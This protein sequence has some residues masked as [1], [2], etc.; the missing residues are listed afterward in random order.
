MKELKELAEFFPKKLYAVGGYVRDVLSGF[1][2]HDIDIAADVSP[3]EVFSILEKT[4][5]SVKETSK[6]LMTLKIIGS[7]T[8]YYEYTAFRTDSY[9]D[10]HTPTAVKRTSDIKI[11]ALRRDFTMN[12]IYL[13]IETGEFI[14]PLNGIEDIKDKKVRMTRESTFEEDGLRLMRLCRQ[15]AELG[16][17]IEEKTLISAQNNAFRIDEISPERIREELDRILVADIRYGV[18]DAQCRGLRLLDEIGV[19]E[20]ILPEITKGK[21]MEQRKDFHKFDVFNHILE[22]V[23]LAPPEIRLA[24]LLHDVGKPYCMEKFGKYSRH[25]VEGEWI[26]KNILNRLRYSNAVTKETLFLV[27]NHMFDLRLECNEKEIILFLQQNFENLDK[28]YLLKVADFRASGVQQGDCPAVVR[29]AKILENMKKNGAP[30]SI[31][32]LKVNGEDLERMGVEPVKRGKL[33][34]NLLSECALRS[35]LK[36]RER[37]LQ[38]VKEYI[39]A[40]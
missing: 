2:S 20:R 19:L 29:H 31:S 35:D 14:D 5:F 8:S 24:A 26:A 28:L 22:T 30:F 15:A 18:K 1:S 7:P 33:L 17:S 36:T 9:E 6:K 27:R 4:P 39:N 37:Q 21:G 10:G 11:D 38:Y 12:A 25:A 23:K 3:E 32:E 13:D 40:N 34:K 16:F